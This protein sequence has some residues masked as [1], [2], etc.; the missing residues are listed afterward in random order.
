MHCRPLDASLESHQH[1]AAIITTTALIL[2]VAILGVS[3]LTAATMQLRMAANL[4]HQKRAFQAAEF[5]IEQAIFSADPSTSDTLAEPMIFPANGV[6][7]RIPDSQGDSYGYRLYFDSSAGATPPPEG[8]DPGLGLVAYHFVIIAIG[9][10]M[11]GAQATHTQSFYVLGPP[12][13][14]RYPASCNLD[15][16]AR[17]K[18]YW[19]QLDAE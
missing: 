7:A 3:G 14:D 13:C 19:S 5:A 12:G 6:P 9:R 8:S 2:V 18:T 1:G 4:Q 10:S 11:R 15:S 16:A 17:T